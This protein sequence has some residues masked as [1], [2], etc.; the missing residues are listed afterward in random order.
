MI[1][2]NKLLC[3]LSRDRVISEIGKSL[4]MCPSHLSK[5]KC[6]GSQPRFNKGVMLLD[7][8]YANLALRDFDACVESV[9]TAIYA[10]VTKGNACSTDEM[11]RQQ[12][13]RLQPTIY[14]LNQPPRESGRER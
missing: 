8:A 4:S 7:Y 13:T 1:D 3:L 2:W 10:I 5:I 9:P 12:T 14:A 6:R 11:A